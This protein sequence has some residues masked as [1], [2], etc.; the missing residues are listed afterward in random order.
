MKS[1]I[2]FVLALQFFIASIFL[3]GGLL[4]FKN[5]LTYTGLENNS[6]AD[7][8]GTSLVIFLSLIFGLGWW[9][10]N[11]IEYFISTNG[12]KMAILAFIGIGLA[13]TLIGLSSFMLTI[14]DFFRISMRAIGYIL[15]SGFF[16]RFSAI[17]PEVFAKLREGN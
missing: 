9:F 5:A 1:Q 4:N 12:R 8:W 17:N 14:S 7:N 10:E 2:K 3:F 6:L 11:W 16:F 13:F 15:I